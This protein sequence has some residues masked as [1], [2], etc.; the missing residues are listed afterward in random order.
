VVYTRAV[1]PTDSHAAIDARVSQ[2]DWL[3]LAKT[4]EPLS[5]DMLYADPPF[6]TGE[7]QKAAEIG[8]AHV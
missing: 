4:L 5:V 2:G 3:T 7:P 6:N 8:R 1:Q